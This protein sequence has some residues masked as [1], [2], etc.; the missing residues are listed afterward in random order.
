MLNNRL[1]F[2]R[3]LHQHAGDQARLGVAQGLYCR[4]RHGV[5]ES[6]ARNLHSIFDAQFG[7][8]HPRFGTGRGIHR[9]ATMHSLVRVTGYFPNRRSI[10][11]E[12]HGYALLAFMV[13]PTP[14]RVL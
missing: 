7:S 2:L 10:S 5:Y 3:H 4:N 6:D 8:G 14:V 1:P 11:A 12:A 9:A 13:R